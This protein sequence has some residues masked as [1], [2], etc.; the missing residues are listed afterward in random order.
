MPSSGWRLLSTIQP[1]L[2]AQFLAWSL[3]CAFG[4]H[5]AVVESAALW[6]N[7]IERDEPANEIN[8]LAQARPI[9]HIV[10]H[11]RESDYDLSLR[12]LG[13]IRSLYKAFHANEPLAV[14]L[15][16]GVQRCVEANPRASEVWK[17]EEELED[18]CQTFPDNVELR[19]QLALTIHWSTMDKIDSDRS[20]EALRSLDRLREVHVL[21]LSS[22]RIAEIRARSTS[23]VASRPKMRGRVET[24]VLLDELRELQHNFANSLNIARDLARVLAY[25]AILLEGESLKDILAELRALRSLHAADERI[26]EYL[27]KGLTSVLVLLPSEPRESREE[28]LRELDEARQGHFGKGQR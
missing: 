17:A 28:V 5:Q 4:D 13:H 8:A 22:E 18:L 16:Q 25:S 1:N 9:V 23:L 10:D 24:K 15:A 27:V 21:D 6:M 11:L 12:L 3:H 7:S 14:T 20:D 2:Q 19:E 26:R